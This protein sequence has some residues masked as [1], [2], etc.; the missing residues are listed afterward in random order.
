MH[1]K[2]KRKW[3]N[4]PVAFKVTLWYTIFLLIIFLGIS[5]FAVKFSETLG[6]QTAAADLEKQVQEA[7]QH[8]EKFDEHEDGVYLSL[9]D[10]EGHKLRGRLPPGMLP[11]APRR[12]GLGPQ[13][14]RSGKQEYRY[15][16]LSLPGGDPKIMRG[17]ISLDK[18]AKRTQHLLTGILVALPVFI[19][20]AAV[21]GYLLIK[22]GFAPVRAISAAA[23][24]IGRTKDLSRRIDIGTGRDEIHQMA[25][26]FNEMLD[27]IE[28]SVAR[29]KQFS[30]DVSHELRTPTAVIMAESEYGRD[31]IASL[32]EAKESFA[33]IFKQTQKMKALI[34]QLL[35][36]AR[37]GQK[38]KVARE[39]L[40][41]SV[42]VQDLI[43]DYEQ[44]AAAKNLQLETEITP[45]L[46]VRGNGLLLQR[47]A[48]NYLDNALKFTKSRIKVVLQKQETELRLSV[49]DDGPGLDQDEAAKI[50]ER[51]YQTDKSRNKKTNQGL[52]LGLAAVALI[53][54]LHQGK[55]GVKSQPG[56][57]CE[58]YVE[59]PADTKEVLPGFSG[60]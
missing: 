36:L 28:G 24:D 52:G 51:F 4:W 26:A 2:L 50:W 45:D 12:P 37:L 1:L 41:L 21:G 60:N 54:E 14:F 20:L 25:G 48:A 9:Y 42:L 7:A 22:K 33:S 16:D 55:A 46:W 43:K 6:R 35:E 27:Q 34:N 19:L 13:D 23:R 31:C 15:Y 56:Q 5:L 58:F 10:K 39:R 40:N 49:I 32:P 11:E 47:L 38:D 18:I 59:L 44:L 30:N 8:P 53:A 57:G 3:D 17:V 29:E